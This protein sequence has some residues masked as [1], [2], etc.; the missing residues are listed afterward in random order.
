MYSVVPITTKQN[1]GPKG[2]LILFGN[3]VGSSTEGGSQNR[4][5]RI[6]THAVRPKGERHGWRESIPPIGR[7][8]GDGATDI[9]DVAQMVRAADS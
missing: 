4:R 9:G 3:D 7:K 6:W 8:A 5:K 1:K 2:T